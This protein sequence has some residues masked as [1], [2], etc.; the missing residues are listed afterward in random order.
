MLP[1]AMALPEFKN[2]PKK[3]IPILEKLKDDE[4]EYVRKSVANNL[5][6]ISKTNPETVLN[7]CE[8]WQGKSEN[9]DWIIKHGCRTLLK[10][11]N[12]RAMLLFGF[13]NPKN[14]HVKNVKVNK[15]NL[16]IGDAVTFTFDLEVNSKTEKLV[17]LEYIVHYVKKNNKISPKVF[18]I[19]ESNLNPG[20]HKI[21]KKQSFENVSTRTHSPGKHL[22]EI[23]VNGEVKN[24]ISIE[25][26]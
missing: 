18:Q 14:I 10:T 11:G 17:R 15:P 7:I 13:A 24:S 20:V 3:I 26:T 21:E 16:K 22:I 2:D 6:D 8:K 25:L 23:K 9:T 19:K 12:K 4:S 5:N 1:W